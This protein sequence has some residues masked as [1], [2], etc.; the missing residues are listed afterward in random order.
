M[1]KEIKKTTTRTNQKET[2][3]RRFSKTGAYVKTGG[4]SAPKVH[5]R[6]ALGTGPGEKK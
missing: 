6:K 1:V 2:P 5:S 4:T 3:S